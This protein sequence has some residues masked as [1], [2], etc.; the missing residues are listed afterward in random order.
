MKSASEQTAQE[1]QDCLKNEKSDEE[2]L[3]MI[4]DKFWHGYIKSIYP[5]DAI[6]L[7]TSIMIQLIKEFFKKNI[8]K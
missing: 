7:N 6:N 8:D 3:R 4:K 2:I 5:E 1:I